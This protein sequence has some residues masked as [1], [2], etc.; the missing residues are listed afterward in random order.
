MDY[1]I[2]T[3]THTKERLEAPC[4]CLDVNPARMHIPSLKMLY[5][6]KPRTIREV[7]QGGGPCKCFNAGA[8]LAKHLVLPSKQE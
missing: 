8:R 5:S 7:K 4:I 3:N 1:F 6:P 2:S